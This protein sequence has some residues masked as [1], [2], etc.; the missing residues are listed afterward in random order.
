MTVPAM[1][2]AQRLARCGKVLENGTIAMGISMRSA[3]P[4]RKP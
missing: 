2:L 1:M 4:S 3:A